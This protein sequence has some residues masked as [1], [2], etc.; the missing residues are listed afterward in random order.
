MNRFHGINCSVNYLVL[1]HILW[2]NIWQ[3]KLVLIFAVYWISK[4]AQNKGLYLNRLW[5]KSITYPNS[6]ILSVTQMLKE[7][8]SAQWELLLTALILIEK[9]LRKTSV[10]NLRSL[11]PHH[12]M[13]LAMCFCTLANS[14]IFLAILN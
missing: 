6:L 8:S 2:E 11:T 9:M 7:I 10:S 4:R 1:F 3:K 5:T 14:K 12:Q 13:T